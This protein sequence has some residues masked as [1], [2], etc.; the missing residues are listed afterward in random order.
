[1]SENPKQIGKY[2]VLDV[3][4]HGNVGVVYSGYDPFADRKVAI[5]VCAADDRSADGAARLFRKM[6]FNEAHT[7]ALL[8]HPNILKIY[9]AGEEAGEPYII[10]EYVEGGRTLKYYCDQTRL[11]PVERV[12]EIG[13]KCAKALDYAHRRGVI[14]RDIEPS[15]I[16]LTKNGDVKIGDF[17]IA[18]RTQGDVTQVLGIVGS[19]LY[20]SPEQACEEDVNTQTDLYSLGVVLF[21]LLTGRLPFESVR[22]STLIQQVIYEIPPTITSLRSELPET[23]AKVVAKALEKNKA[24]GVAPD[25]SWR[26]I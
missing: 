7:A 12:I 21:E 13:F 16:M 11:L 14:H 10:M 26:P 6:F 24:N 5:K 17:G 20:M 15:N 4:G 18:Q 2:S 25:S 23:L 8:D 9:D 1:M 19:A 22:F 3:A